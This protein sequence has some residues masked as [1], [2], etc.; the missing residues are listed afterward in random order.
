MASR[1]GSECRDCGW[2]LGVGPVGVAAARGFSEWAV[3]AMAGRRLA[4]RGR[5]LKSFDLYSDSESPWAAC[6]PTPSSPASASPSPLVAL[7]FKFAS[8]VVWGDVRFR[9]THR[10]P[11]APPRNQTLCPHNGCRT[12]SLMGTRE[13]CRPY[14]ARYARAVSPY[15]SQCGAEHDLRT[16]LDR[17]AHPPVKALVG[18][19]SISGCATLAPEAW[20][21]AGRQTWV[22]K[23]EA[24]HIVMC[25][26]SRE[27][28]GPAHEAR[29]ASVGGWAGGL[30][31][32]RPF[33]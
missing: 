3:A 28:R 11:A 14:P 23:L 1:A 9:H 33:D 27:R 5:K 13:S 10:Q 29:F 31:V 8:A 19:S 16:G 15:D 2:L 18:D 17:L 4:N 7:P 25:V 20:L 21:A 12:V 22:A 32:S 6:P 24:I 26:S 30:P